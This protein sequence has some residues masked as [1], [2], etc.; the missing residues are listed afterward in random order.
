MPHFLNI[1]IERFD[2]QT[3]ENKW[4]SFNNFGS[5][6]SLSLF[7][8]STF[9]PMANRTEAKNNKA[10]GKSRFRGLSRVKYATIR[11]AKHFSRILE[12]AKSAL[13]IPMDN[14][15]LDI[16]NLSMGTQSTDVSMISG[17]ADEYEWEHLHNVSSYSSV[18]SVPD[19]ICKY[20]DK[21]WTGRS[22]VGRKGTPYKMKLPNQLSRFNKSTPVSKEIS[23]MKIKNKENNENKKLNLTIKDRL[24]FK[25]IPNVLFFKLNI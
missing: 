10:E 25:N 24:K 21:K 9:P 1:S 20:Q 12:K 4:I 11:V 2:I 7:E 22:T 14:Y 23:G 8:V 19:K 6:T 5:S 18:T 16:S 13:T 15:A 3:D 17:C